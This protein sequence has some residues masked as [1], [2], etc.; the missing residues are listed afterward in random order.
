VSDELV[1]KGLAHYRVLDVLGK[2][3]MSVVYRAVDVRLDRPVALKVMNDD[4]SADPEFRER[5][6]QEA[7]A[8]S[9]LDHVNVVPLYD[10]GQTDGHLY[11][12]MRLVDGTD[13]AKEIRAGRLSV[14]RVLSLLNQVGAALDMLHARGLVHLDV[15]PAN[16]LITRNESVGTEHVYLAD[17]GL[18]RRD[19]RGAQTESGDFLGSPSYASPEHLRGEAIVPAADIYSLTCMLFTALAGRGPFVGDV[20]TVITGHLSGQVPSLAALTG[21]PPAIDR[22]IARGMA[23][24]PAARYPTAADLLGAARKALSSA[25]EPVGVGTVHPRT[26]VLGAVQP[27]GFAG[28]PPGAPPVGAA[29]GAAAGPPVGYRVDDPRTTQVRPH[30]LPGMPPPGS[31]GRPTSHR[32]IP[33]ERRPRWPWIVGGVMLLVAVGVVVALLA[34]GGG[35]GSSGVPEAPPVSG[36]VPTSAAASRPTVG[37]DGGAPS[38]ITVPLPPTLLTPTLPSNLRTLTGIPDPFTSGG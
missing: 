19:A 28:Y 3:G 7:K 9:A 22:V 4:L 34:F 36:S 17:F 38:S 10:F 27:A 6:E 23:T 24:D 5:F 13:L 31:A 35:G 29:V 30:Q 18:T 26:E 16:V 33:V 12:A 37:T 11:I 15:K 8:A 14:R 20:R 21:L 25:D 32:V 2:G 1:G